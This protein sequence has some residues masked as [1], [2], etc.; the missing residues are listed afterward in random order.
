MAE[1]DPLRPPTSNVG[2]G[3]KR[4]IGEGSGDAAGL[5]ASVTVALN[6]AVAAPPG[7]RRGVIVRGRKH[8]APRGQFQGRGIR[9]VAPVENDG[10][11]VRGWVVD[12]AAQVERGPHG[13]R[14]R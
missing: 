9:T 8:R 5:E 7:K 10:L 14:R 11:E 12:R 13:Q 4:P 3:D 1:V 2:V 6:V